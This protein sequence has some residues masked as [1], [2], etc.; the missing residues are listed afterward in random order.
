MNDRDVVIQLRDALAESLG[1]QSFELWFGANTHF[2][3]TGTIVTVRATSQFFHDWLRR[4]FRTKIE[5]C[6][7]DVIGTSASV[8]FVVSSVATEGDDATAP[9]P[10]E[11]AKRPS[12]Q[13]VVPPAEPLRAAAGAPSARSPRQRRI[14]SPPAPA[15]PGAAGEEV[16]LKFPMAANDTVPTRRRFAR[17]D[18]FVVGASNRLAHTSAVMS[19]ERPGTL[20][21]L[22]IYG[23]TGVGKT[24]LLE[25]IWSAAMQKRLPGGAVYLTAE[26]FTSFFL[27]A[28]NRSGLPNFRRK[29]RGVGLLLIDDLQFFAGKRATLVELLYTVGTLAEMGRQIVLASDRA[30]NEIPELGDELITRLEGGMLCRVEQPEYET[31]RGIV[32]RVARQMQ[33]EVPA[34]VADFVAEQITSHP[35]ALAGALHRLHA[36]SQALGCPIDLALA[37]DALGDMI[38]RSARPV[39]MADIERAV[40][41]V[42][43]LEPRS[44]QSSRK[45]KE[46]SYPRMFAMWLARKHTRAALA[47]IGTYFGRRS[48]ATVLSAQQKVNDWVSNR[49]PVTLSQRTWNADEAVRALEDRLRT[50]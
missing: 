47:E 24:H 18:E 40:C 5:A 35:R 1:Q 9:V 46:V 10:Q 45:A 26:Q 31:R 7:R 44:L 12:P 39:R 6:A 38:Q 2:D 8:R 48:H 4:N 11:T 32:T 28:L 29:Y 27:E 50:G 33:L 43:G 19:T 49:A 21:P 16:T 34:A 13:V 20:S 37:Q 3:V 41:Q 23:S 15:L 17:L 36:T 30:P 25:G 14:A 42:F 22:V